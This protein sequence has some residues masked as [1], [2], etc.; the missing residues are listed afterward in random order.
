MRRNLSPCARVLSKTWARRDRSRST[1][2]E[3]RIKTVLLQSEVAWRAAMLEAE[4]EP[5][6]A[7]ED[8]TGKE[9]RNNNEQTAT[10]IAGAAA[11]TI[12]NV[13]L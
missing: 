11:A 3:T 13:I 5:V 2:A 1:A 6:G 7:K 12:A 9:Q 8:A 4:I 10:A